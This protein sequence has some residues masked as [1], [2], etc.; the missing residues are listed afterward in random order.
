MG[1][2]ALEFPTSTSEVGPILLSVLIGAVVL[3]TIYG[4]YRLAV[5]AA[6]RR[7]RR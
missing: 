7:R 3:G 5:A 2:S 4:V 6:R 1:P